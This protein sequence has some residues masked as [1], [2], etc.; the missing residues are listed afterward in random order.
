MVTAEVW[1][2]AGMPAPTI[3]EFNA[4]GGDFL[5]A[6]ATTW[7]GPNPKPPVHAG[8]L[9]FVKKETPARGTR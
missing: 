1:S 7:R 4:S 9:F 5:C 3:R 6:T 2:A 8:S